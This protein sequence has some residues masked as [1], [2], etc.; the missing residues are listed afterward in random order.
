MLW[1]SSALTV[2]SIAV[3]VGKTIGASGGKTGSVFGDG[4][5]VGTAVNVGAG[6]GCIALHPKRQRTI[7]TD[8]IL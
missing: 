6:I 1:F 2:I 8:E 4:V 3:L 5:L 7:I